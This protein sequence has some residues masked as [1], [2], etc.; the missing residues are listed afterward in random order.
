MLKKAKEKYNILYDHISNIHVSSSNHGNKFQSEK[1][2]Q[3]FILISFHG[4]SLMELLIKNIHLSIVEINNEMEKSFLQQYNISFD[5]SI[6]FD[7]IQIIRSPEDFVSFIESHANQAIRYF[8]VLYL[9]PL[10][11][12]YISIPICII[13]QEIGNANKSITKTFDDVLNNLKTIGM[14]IIGESFDRDPGLLSRINALVQELSN[15]ILLHPELALEDLAELAA[16]VNSGRFIY[17]DLLHL[18]K[19]DRYR[20]VSGVSIC[21]TLYEANATINK[22]SFE[23]SGILKWIT[24]NNHYTKMDDTL[25]IKFFTLENIQHLREIKRFDLSFSLM[26]STLFIEAVLN[27]NYSKS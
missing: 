26:T 3:F 19:C 4:R 13:P 10:N 15:L 1:L 20:K 6:E 23:Q 14:D 11:P 7:A 25:P 24:D 17:I 18:T 16:H 5:G 22:E 21:P 12:N 27:E 8:F 2:H 9:C